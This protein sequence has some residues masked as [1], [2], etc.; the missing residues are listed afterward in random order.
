MHF[1]LVGRT[2]VFRRGAEVFSLVS[3]KIS[4]S[5]REL[6]K[7]TRATLAIP[8]RVY[9]FVSLSFFQPVL[10][11]FYLSIRFYTIAL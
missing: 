7:E 4:E 11:S 3:R 9:F 10:A 5:A 2:A 8:A 6:A 1:V